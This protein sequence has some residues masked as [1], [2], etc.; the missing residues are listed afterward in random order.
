M[1]TTY[2]A[3]AAEL[4]ARGQLIIDALEIMDAR[5]T[6]G[7]ESG[8]LALI[9]QRTQFYAASGSLTSTAPPAD[10]AAF[11]VW[12]AEL[13]ARIPV[14]LQRDAMQIYADVVCLFGHAGPNTFTLLFRRRARVVELLLCQQT[15]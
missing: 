7:D 13:A 11:A 1:P 15:T 3:K 10:E 12:K 5:R 9:C 8:A 2:P 6:S 14:A 4:T